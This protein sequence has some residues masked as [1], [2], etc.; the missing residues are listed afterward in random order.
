MLAHGMVH[1]YEL[2]LPILVTIWLS[3]FTTLDLVV[4]SFAVT[5]AVLGAVLAA[6]YGLFGLGA[7]PGGVLAD[8]YGSRIL[9]LACLVGMGGSFLLLSLAPTLA[10]VAFAL[11]LW[12]AAA[13]VYHPSGL[14]LISKGVNERGSAFAYHG[15]AGNLGI[16]LGPLATALLLLVLDWRVVVALL[17]VPALLAAVAA[18]RI[19]VDETA[20]VA[21]DG[22]DARAGGSVTSFTEFLADSQRLFAGSFIAVFAVV[23][24]SGLYYRGILSFLPE[25]LGDYAVFALVEV[26]GREVQPSRYVYV[27]ILM[28][29]IVGQY[30]GG[31]LTDRI[32]VELGLAAGYGS[33]GVLAVLFLPVA[34]LGLVPFLILGTLLGVA[35][36]VVQPFYQ[37]T[38]AEYTP[39]GTRGLSYGYTYLGVFGVGALGASVAGTALTY[40]SLPV[41]FGVLAA[42]G[43]AAGLL[44]AV[45][46][47]RR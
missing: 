30:V 1:T 22:G 21:S 34:S 41:L 14:A 19:K 29:G 9:I 15:M 7:L 44:G 42:F 11:I 37:A 12:G 20:A 46:Y 25:I 6:G 33:L 3:E 13:S 32:P 17:A 38:V 35:L 16:A 10:I 31:K 28:A 18:T 36:F 26:A 27:G 23:I 40:Y 8:A 43:L 39:A 47:L 4:A 24:L 2:S 5:P 45:L